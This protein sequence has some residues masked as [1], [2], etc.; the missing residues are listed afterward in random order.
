MRCRGIGSEIV[1]LWFTLFSQKL[2]CILCRLKRYN[3]I[4]H[5]DWGEKGILRFSLAISVKNISSRKRLK[6][7]LRRKRNLPLTNST[8]F[9][10][11]NHHP[12]AVCTAV[13]YVE[14]EVSSACD[15]FA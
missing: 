4:Q 8:A 15:I 3:L 1:L 13:S 12:T 7:S 9:T 2:V 14:I 6:D 10:P 5:E 11:N